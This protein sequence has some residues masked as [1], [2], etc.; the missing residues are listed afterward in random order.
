MR[1]TLLAAICCCLAA[2]DTGRAADPQKIDSVPVAPS[3]PCHPVV[4]VTMA[5]EKASPGTAQ[6]PPTDQ[7]SAKTP[8]PLPP[9]EEPKPE[10]A[11]SE[12][13]K[14]D[15]FFHQG[16]YKFQIGGQYR[17]NPNFSNFP[18]Q[19]VTLSPADESSENFAQQ[20]LR[21]WLTAVIDEHIDGY[22]QVQ[23]GG[24]LWGQNFE[25]SKVFRPQPGSLPN[26]DVGIMLRRGWVSY[27][28][29]NCGKFRM[30]ILDWH[31]SFGDTLASSD[32]DFNVAGI[33]WTKTIPE[34][35]DMKA[36]LGFF[37]MT[38]LALLES[39]LPPGNHDALLFTS[40]FDWKYEETKSGFGFSAYGM[41]DNGQYSY[42]TLTPYR[43]SWDL[44]V[45]ARGNTCLGDALPVNGFVL[46]NGGQREDIGGA[47]FRHNGWAT[48]LE[49]GPLD[50]GPG[51]LSVQALYASGSHHPEVGDTDEFRTIAQTY[52]DNFG[53]QG[54]WGYLYILAP[55]PPSD[56]KDL[57]VSLQNRGLGLFTIQGKYVYPIKCKLSGIF[58]AGWSTADAPNPISGGRVIGPEV[59]NQ[60]VYDFGH[61]LTID[62]GV[63]MLFT[64][65]FYRAG[66]TAP[67]P[68]D[69]Y[70]VF[71]RVQ[72]EF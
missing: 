50:F 64:G 67:A 10:E 39:D 69:L 46:Y 15:N 6:V 19:P 22:V 34:L 38:D 54:Y 44:W 68:N 48:K 9:E 51:K 21:L 60:F 45:G 62:L 26:N 52:R 57:G 20:R 24:F 42:P 32:Y 11:A 14:P 66:P 3:S 12:E 16:D 33:D 55:N 36:W 29:D 70:M 53:A 47:I 13:P 4:E 23:I 65:D 31:D 61:G 27:H 25:F 56:V 30:G 49:A 71:S 72:L 37:V 7:A 17:I 2:S 59:A 41:M 8:P 28:D 18:F 1:A 63:A 58:A 5:D 35:G 40:D 43:S